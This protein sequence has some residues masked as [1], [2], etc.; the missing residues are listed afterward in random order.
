MRRMV[1]LSN[2]VGAEAADDADD[3]DEEEEVSASGW[4]ALARMWGGSSPRRAGFFSRNACRYP[5]LDAASCSCLAARASRSRATC[6]G[7][8]AR[9]DTAYVPDDMFCSV[10]PLSCTVLGGPGCDLCVFTAERVR[11]SVFTSECVYAS[12]HGGLSVWVSVGGWV[13]V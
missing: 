5:A 11:V 8:R 1:A 13:Y 12:V 3:E 9:I 7:V 6:A 10:G 4:P 2:E